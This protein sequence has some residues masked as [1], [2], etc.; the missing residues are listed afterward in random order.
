MATAMR[1]TL[2]ARAAKAV[3]FIAQAE[4]RVTNPWPALGQE[5]VRKSV[6]EQLLR[7]PNMNKTGRLPGFAM[8]HAGMCARLTQSVEPSEAVVDAVGKVRGLDFHP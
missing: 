8:F 4:D 1:C 5:Q 3:L 7:H 6:G 2:S